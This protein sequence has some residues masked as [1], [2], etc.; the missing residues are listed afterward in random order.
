MVKVLERCCAKAVAQVLV[1][2]GTS[3][4]MLMQGVPTE[5]EVHTAGNAAPVYRVLLCKQNKVHHPEGP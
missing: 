3:R 2:R 4:L 5:R 1:L